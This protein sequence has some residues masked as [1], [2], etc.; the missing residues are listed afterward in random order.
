M[1]S[2]SYIVI[3]EHGN[4]T[5]ESPRFEHKEVAEYYIQKIRESL[6]LSDRALNRALPITFEIKEITLRYAVMLISD[7]GDV[8]VELHATKYEAITQVRKLNVM[9]SEMG[10]ETDYYYWTII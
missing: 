8:I 1:T 4:E 6:M 9:L 5:I 2:K 7:F 10:I 3:V